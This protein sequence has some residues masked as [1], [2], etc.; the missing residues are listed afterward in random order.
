GSWH[1]QL[2]GGCMDFRQLTDPK[3]VLSAIDE[4]DTRGRENF[5]SWHKYG[6][7]R[8]FFLKYQTRLY[9]SKAI[10]GVACG[11]QFGNALSS[12][13]FSGGEH[14]VARKLKELGFDVE[15]VG[16]AS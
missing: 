1:C 16:V 10:V 2:I 5:L 4:F 6:H 14:T 9:D 11:Y 3:A 7:A 13:D 12:S 15:R 8:S